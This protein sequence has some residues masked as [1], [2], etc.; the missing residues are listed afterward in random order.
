VRAIN[1]RALAESW[2]K[3][4]AGRGGGGVG[5]GPPWYWA[6][7]GPSSPCCRTKAPAGSIEAVLSGESGSD[8]PLP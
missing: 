5:P 8:Q 3:T 7:L 1:T 4:V 6:T 2:Q